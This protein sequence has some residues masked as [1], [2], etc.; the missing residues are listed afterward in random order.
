M[1]RRSIGIIVNG[2]TGRMGY[3]QHLVRSLLAIR[4]SGGVA[5]ADGTTI[6]PEPV[7]VGRNETKLRELAERHG[8]TDW[9]TDLTSAL[10][11]DDVEIYFDAQVTQQR[12]KAIRQAIE[13]G[14]HIYTEKPLAEDTAA[15][16]DLARAADAAGVRTGV[17]QDKL[18]LPGLRKLKR[19]IDGGFFGRILS[20]RGEFGYWVFEGDWQPAQRPSWNYRN[21]DG[22][23]IVVDMFPHWHYVLEELFGRVTAVSCVTAT[24][25]PERVDEAGHP[26]AATADDAAYATFELDGGVIAQIN[27]SWAVRVYRDELVEF[28]V[29][30]TEGSAIAGLR[31]CRVQHRAVTPKPV[32]NPDLPATED[33]RAQWAEVPDNEEFDNG[34]KVQWEAYLRHVVAGEPFRW[35]FLAGARGVQLA[36]LGLRSAREGGRIEVPELRS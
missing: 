10:A 25:V 32:W 4:E 22:G 20:V 15:A 28:Q 14:K 8:L 17:V 9:T 33:F 21:E 16:L 7:L 18:F 2:V 31:N 27:S 29:D 12:E 30:G 23:G 36:E 19:L 34:F 26:Y 13:A 11:R 6:W 1:T 5:L 35:D 24:H 3:R